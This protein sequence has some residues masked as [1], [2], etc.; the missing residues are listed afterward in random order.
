MLQLSLA[1]HKRECIEGENTACFQPVPLVFQALEVTN[2]KE[3]LL[4]QPQLL[5]EAHGRDGTALSA[6]GGED[7]LVTQQFEIIS[8]LGRA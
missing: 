8:T 3:T 1:K 6:S 7:C 5:C 4:G 2:C